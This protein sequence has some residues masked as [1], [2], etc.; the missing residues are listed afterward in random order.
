MLTWEDAKISCHDSNINYTNV[1]V[2]KDLNTTVER[3]EVRL[4]TKMVQNDLKI[5][6]LHRLDF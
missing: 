6:G 2:R 3:L 5:E 1:Q 4:H